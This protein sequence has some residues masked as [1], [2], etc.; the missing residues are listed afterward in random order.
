MKVW[1]SFTNQ[2]QWKEYLLSLLDK[3]D[4]AVKKAIINESLGIFYKSETMERVFVI[5]VG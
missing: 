1:E 3:N 5:F 4:V 2:K